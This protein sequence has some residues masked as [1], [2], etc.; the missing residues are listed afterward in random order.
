MHGN[1]LMADSGDA[2]GNACGWRGFQM[3]PPL[4]CAR[5]RA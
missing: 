2:S 5:W 3:L 1:G 4:F